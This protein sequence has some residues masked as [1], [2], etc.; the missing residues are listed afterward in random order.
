[1]NSPM[2]SVDAKRAETKR[3]RFGERLFN[4]AA[5]GTWHVENVR[6]TL[7]DF[8]WLRARG[9]AFRPFLEIGA[10]HVQRSLALTNALGADGAATDIS[11]DALR[12]TPFMLRLLQYERAPLVICCDAHHLPFLPN[13][14]QFAFA[15]QTLHHFANP[16]PVIGECYRVL[17]SGGHFFFDEEPMDS[18]LR[19]RLRGRRL[20]SHP[21]TRVQRVAAC[22]RV[23]KLF[24]DDG[25]SERR[26]GI[27]EARFDLS[28][29]REALQPFTLLDLQVNRYARIH[30]NLHAS[31]F[32]TQLAGLIG[33]NVKGLCAKRDG[34][35]ISKNFQERLMCVDCTSASFARNDSGLRCLHCQRAYPIHDGVLRMLPRDLE[36]QLYAT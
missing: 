13:T 16:A 8:E 6:K 24:W 18:W 14:F 22:M 11:H 1:M 26:S 28:S 5:L 33:G 12:D 25:A 31:A 34:E 21:P 3:P 7:A 27:T 20:L 10:G 35:P 36:N 9:V 19:R 29:W 4:N 17:G 2:Q 30:T 32:T 23:E 15:Y